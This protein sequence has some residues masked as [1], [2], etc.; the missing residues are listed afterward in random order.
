[1][2]GSDSDRPPCF[3]KTCMSNSLNRASSRQS[4]KSK[5]RWAVFQFT[6]EMPGL[7]TVPASW[8]KTTEKMKAEKSKSARCYQPRKGSVD[9]LSVR[10]LIKTCPDPNINTWVLLPGLFK[11]YHESMSKADINITERLG[12]QNTT[13]S[14]LQKLDLL[15]K[16]KQP[17]V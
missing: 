3:K 2:S 6:G 11:D 16:K 14:E 1:M 5:K 12:T 4:E 8:V 7:M 15:G 9:E 10:K 13:D 17:K